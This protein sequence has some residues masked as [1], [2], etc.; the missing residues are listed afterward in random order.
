MRTRCGSRE[1]SRCYLCLSICEID[2]AIMRGHV[3]FQARAYKTTKNMQR[4]HGSSV[5][6]QVSCIADCIIQGCILHKK[7]KP[8]NRTGSLAIGS[9][10]CI[11]RT[12][13]AKGYHIHAA[14]LAFVINKKQ[15]TE[16][17]QSTIVKSTTRPKTPPTRTGQPITA[18]AYSSHYSCN[19]QLPCNCTPQY[20]SS[21]GR[22][23]RRVADLAGN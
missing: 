5:I 8:W 14:G 9:G 12:L 18:H 16:K 10:N 2:Q 3:I 17:K 4:R 20:C 19:M 22:R 7:K 21:V 11:G 13:L 23:K 15:Y 6:W 1:D